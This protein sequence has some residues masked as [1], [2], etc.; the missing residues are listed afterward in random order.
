[1]RPNPLGQ[2]KDLKHSKLLGAVTNIIICLASI[3]VWET[4]ESWGI[5]EWHHASSACALLQD[6]MVASF[7]M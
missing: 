1:M 3:K 5:V 6:N 2:L 7:T 4:V